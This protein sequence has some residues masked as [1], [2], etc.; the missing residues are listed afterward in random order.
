MPRRSTTKKVSVKKA[1]TIAAA[2]KKFN[3][4]DLR[5]SLSLVVLIGML[6]FSLLLLLISLN[7]SAVAGAK[8][9]IAKTVPMGKTSPKKA[10]SRVFDDSSLGFKLTMPA[11]L[12]EWSYKTGEVKSLTDESLSNRY[13]QIFVPIPGAKSNN[14]EEQN[15]N[16]LTIRKFS[17]EEWKDVSASCKKDKKD[18]CDAAGTLAGESTDS[19]GEEWIYAYIKP[20]DCP[21]GIEAKCKLADKIIESFQLK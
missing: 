2:P 10:E 20:S 9:H 12:G 18:I 13:L 14:L 16:I 7:K 3:Q 21:T 19:D 15:K 11:Q 17:G 6:S 1:K 4:K 5:F 8:T